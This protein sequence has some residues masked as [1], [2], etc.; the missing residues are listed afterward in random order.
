VRCLMLAPERCNRRFLRL[1]GWCYLAGLLLILMFSGALLAEEISRKAIAKTAPSYPELARR[2][3]LTGK[4]RL[5]ILITA[6]GAVNAARL[7]GGNPVF[8]KSAIEAA[9]QW[10]FEPAQKETKAIIVLE[11]AGQ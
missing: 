8:E 4:V 6:G 2:M 3:H 5:E 1:G 10:R 9:K 11:F 7:V